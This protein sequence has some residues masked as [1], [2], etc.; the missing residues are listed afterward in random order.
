L[1]ALNKTSIEALF[2]VISN[3]T[4]VEMCNHHVLAEHVNF[5]WHIKYWKESAALYTELRSILPANARIGREKFDYAL[6]TVFE[7]D[8]R[9]G[10][11]AAI[12]FA[13]SFAKSGIEYYSSAIK[14]VGF[15]YYSKSD[16]NPETKGFF[17]LREKPYNLPLRSLIDYIFVDC[18]TQ[19]ITYIDRDFWRLYRDYLIFQMD[20]FGS[21]KTK[22]PKSLKAEHDILKLKRNLAHELGRAEDFSL[23]NGKIAGLSYAGDDYCI[24]VPDDTRQIADDGVNLGYCVRSYFD[25]IMN[26]VLQKCDEALMFI[27]TKCGYYV[28]IG[29]VKCDYDE[30]SQDVGG[31]AYEKTLIG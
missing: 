30:I 31:G 9:S 2:K 8:R 12:Y 21:I 4:L 5:D 26:V 15:G 22:F 11:D 17:Q 3:E 13:E 24:V 27:L 29:F 7:L 25:R 10:Y 18:Y 1:R 28:K 23:H 20:C 19:G 6:P 16:P 14:G